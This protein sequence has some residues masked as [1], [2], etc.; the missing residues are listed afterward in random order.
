[1]KR[2]NQNIARAVRFRMGDKPITAAQLAIATGYDVK[3]VARRLAAWTRRGSVRGVYVGHDERGVAV[4]G[5]VP[6]G[7]R[8]AIRR[9]PCKRMAMQ[10]VSP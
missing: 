9:S 6:T 1:M 7:A 8:L 10:E 3:L 2:Q 4:I 5:Y